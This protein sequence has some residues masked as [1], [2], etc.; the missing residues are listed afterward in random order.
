[1]FLPDAQGLIFHLET[2]HQPDEVFDLGLKLAPLLSLRT[3]NAH[4]GSHPFNR[5]LSR[6][7]ICIKCVALAIE[8]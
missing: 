1:M 8:S 5:A 4:T 3:C 6:L 2:L 7:R